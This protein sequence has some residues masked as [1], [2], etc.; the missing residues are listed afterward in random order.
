M[1]A[2]EGI[3]L[4]IQ[5]NQFQVMTTSLMAV[6]LDNVLQLTSNVLIF[7][8]VISKLKFLMDDRLK[9][10]AVFFGVEIVVLQFLLLILRLKA[11]GAAMKNGAMLVI[12][13]NG[14]QTWEHIQLLLMEIGPNGLLQKSNVQLPNVKS[15]EVLQ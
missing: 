1:K 13:E 9:I 12:V 10:F 14:I 8:D 5:L 7:G 15:L 4:E 3:A 11:V 2:V 6:S